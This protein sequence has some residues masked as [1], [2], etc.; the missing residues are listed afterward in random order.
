MWYIKYTVI[1]AI[2]GIILAQ[3]IIFAAKTNDNHVLFTSTKCAV[4]VYKNG[5]EIDSYTAEVSI[6]KYYTYYPITIKE[7]NITKVYYNMEK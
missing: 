7:N 5:N 1:P 6:S 4:F 3:I 2:I